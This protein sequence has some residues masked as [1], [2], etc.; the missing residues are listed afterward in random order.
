MA[1]TGTEAACD[2][3]HVCLQ[4][5]RR[6]FGPFHQTGICYLPRLPRPIA[7]DTFKSEGSVMHLSEASHVYLASSAVG[8][9]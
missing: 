4:K 8:Q 1:L 7:A 5:R 6:R 2:H 9:K 3:L